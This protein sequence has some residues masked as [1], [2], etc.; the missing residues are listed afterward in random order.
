MTWFPHEK[1]D[2]NQVQKAQAISVLHEMTQKIY[3]IF[4]TKYSS[5]AWEKTLLHKFYTGIS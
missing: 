1:V 5:D 4:S 3:N 2:G